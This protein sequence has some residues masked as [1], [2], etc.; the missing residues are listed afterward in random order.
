MLSKA[1]ISNFII[2]SF[3]THPLQHSHLCYVHQKMP[4][5]IN[6]KIRLLVT[7]EFKNYI[8]CCIHDNMQACTLWSIFLRVRCLLD[9]LLTM[10]EW[11]QKERKTWAAGSLYRFMG[12]NWELMVLLRKSEWFPMLG[13]ATWI[14]PW[15]NGCSWG[16]AMPISGKNPRVGGVL[17]CDW[18]IWKMEV[19]N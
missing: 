14:K 18:K 1:L 11:T 8:I 3:T 6:M 12:V 10:D 13:L 15:C 19:V 7:C 16:W 4:P 17:P 2:P 5:Y 9:R